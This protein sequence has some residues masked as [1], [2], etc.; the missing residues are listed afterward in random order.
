M[1]HNYTHT[2]LNGVCMYRIWFHDKKVAFNQVIQKWIICNIFF[3]LVALFIF[4]LLDFF[5]KKIQKWGLTNDECWLSFLIKGD[6]FSALFESVFPVLKAEWESL[7]TADD[8]LLDQVQG[9]Y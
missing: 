5:L 1:V 7:V 8:V 4:C 6:D 9:I 3:S 2:Y